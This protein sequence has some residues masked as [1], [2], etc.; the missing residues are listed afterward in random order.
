MVPPHP[1]PPLH[2]PLV[3]PAPEQI[4]D[5][6]LLAAGVGGHRLIEAVGEGLAE[7]VC[8]RRAVDEV[9]LEGCFGHVAGGEAQ[10]A[11]GGA[12]AVQGRL[13]GAEGHEE[14]ERVEEGEGGGGA[15]VGFFRA[16]FLA[17]VGVGG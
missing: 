14:G 5:G 7:G 1:A 11:V 16:G 6:E 2:L 8:A 15:V 12:V 9:L 10:E 17:G 4:R 13:A 3:L